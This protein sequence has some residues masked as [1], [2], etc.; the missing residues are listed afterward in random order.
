MKIKKINQMFLV[1]VLI[2]FTASFLPLGRLFPDYGARLLF[3]ELLLA[4]PGA[5]WIIAGKRNYARTVR[6]NKIHGSTVLLLFLF[7]IAVMPLMSMINA[8]SML[9]VENTTTDTM[10]QVVAGHPFVVSLVLIGL[11][12]CIFEESVYRGLF[13]NEYRK[14]A[15]VGGILLSAFL[16]GIMH[17][18]WNQFSYAF[19]MGIIFS[20][21]IEA[22]DSILSSMLLHFFI[23]ATSVVLLRFMEIFSER[24]PDE[25]SQQALDV[26]EVMTGQT[27][28]SVLRTYLPMAAIGTVAA[29]VI[30]RQIAIKEGRLSAVR[31]IFAK[32]SSMEK[33]GEM[34]KT[35]KWK[36]CASLFSIPLIVAIV[37]LLTVMVLN[38]VL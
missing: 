38:E 13:Y 16:F 4:A 27:F 9:F 14:V 35:G 29:V 33:N 22:T 26:A 2:S 23:N 12:P 7:Y 24:F 28:G 31:A 10:Q 34:G 25:V 30:Y 21:I 3:S 6:L 37:L 36:A 20:L 15:P 1:T 19:V 17:A 5:I 11:L 8:L 18:N 32:K